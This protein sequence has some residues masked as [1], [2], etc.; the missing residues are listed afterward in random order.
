YSVTGLP[1]T[2]TLTPGAVY[3]TATLNWTPTSLQ[4]GTYTAT[5]TVT[6]EGNGT[7]TPASASRTITLVV[8]SSNT[9]PNLA[10]VPDQAAHEGH[11]LTFTL[12][13]SDPNGDALTYSAENLPEGARLDPATGVFD[14]TPGYNQA[15]DYADVKVIVSDGSRSRFD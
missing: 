6:D 11:R 15:G 10:D 5:F 7:G 12:N 2:A 9:A 14:W 3:G 4:A 8:R 1:G 13:A